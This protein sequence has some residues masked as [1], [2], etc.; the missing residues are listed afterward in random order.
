MNWFRLGLAYIQA[1]RAMAIR[2]RRH[3]EARQLRL[4][5]HHFRYVLKHSPF[6]R[7]HF[8]EAMKGWDSP[9]LT[10]E[11]LQTLPL[12]DKETMMTHFNH[13]NTAGIQKEEAF[14]L[15]W[16]GEETRN[17]TPQ[18]GEVTV[19]LSSG[20][21]GNRGLFLV[22]KEEREKWAGTILARV[23]PRGIVNRESVAFFLRANSNL[24]TS[25]RQ[26]WL[27]FAYYDLLEDLS[28]HI[29]R[30]NRQQPTIL[31]APPS[32]LLFLSE[33]KKR[34]RLDI[35]P[36]KVISVADVLD[37]RDRQKI[38]EQFGKPVHQLYQC[39]EGFLA[40]TCPYGTLHL[41]EDLVHIGREWI[42][43]GSGRFIP[44]VTDFSRKTQPIIRYR[45]N[46]ILVL[47]K[48]PCP[49]G[50]AMT[51][52]ARVEGRCDDIFYVKEQKTG[53]YRALFP[54]FIRRAVW[55]AGEEI[56][57]Y[58]VVQQAPDTITVAFMERSGTD[59]KQVEE[60]IRAAFTRLF[61]RLKMEAVTICFTPYHPP[62]AD[63]K[64]R[65]VER[66]WLP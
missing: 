27:I 19:G 52:I 46:D 33:E 14:R 26:R 24:Y 1:K 59:R 3:L 6:Y 45:L 10:W 35:A 34:G 8:Q 13:L 40:A 32:V 23:L 38:E 47:A 9:D 39:T 36:I 11:R 66:M 44:V 41:N 64:L 60:A 51:A 57:Q 30:L 54:D 48:E 28:S 53:Q 15:A 56:L 49:C 50:S 37:N 43:K 21:S 18:I 58:R 7:R 61:H 42:D 22:S 63:K 65:R 29:Q 31:V 12:L 4:I 20:T 25:V 2:S 16:Q 5:R 55:K 17:F 62:A